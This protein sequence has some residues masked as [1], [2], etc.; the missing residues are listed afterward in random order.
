MFFIPEASKMKKRNWVVITLNL[1][2]LF[3]WLYFT[4]HGYKHGY[5]RIWPTVYNYMCSQHKSVIILPHSMANC[6]LG[7]KKSLS[8]PKEQLCCMQC[9]H[10]TNNS[11]NSSLSKLAYWHDGRS[12][13]SWVQAPWTFWVLKKFSSGLLELVWIHQ[14]G[15]WRQILLQCKILFISTNPD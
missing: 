2:P 12:K 4:V 10:I 1:V 13:D 9:L 5:K 7:N 6:F 8:A 11:Q 3:W 14:H 15:H